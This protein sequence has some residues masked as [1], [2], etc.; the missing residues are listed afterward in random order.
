[1]AQNFLFFIV[2][3]LIYISTLFGC[4]HSKYIWTGL[5]LFWNWQVQVPA[6]KLSIWAIQLIFFM[7]SSSIEAN[8]SFVFSVSIINSSTI[9][10]KS[11]SDLLSFSFSWQY[12]FNNSSKIDWTVQKFLFQIMYISGLWNVIIFSVSFRFSNFSFFSVSFHDLAKKNR[13]VSF[14]FWIFFVP[15]RFVSEKNK[16]PIFRFRKNNVSLFC[17]AWIFLFHRIRFKVRIFHLLQLQ[18]E[19][20]KRNL[21]VLCLVLSNLE[22]LSLIFRLTNQPEKKQICLEIPKGKALT[23][24]GCCASICF[25]SSQ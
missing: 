23:L 19:F 4:L 7:E 10:M 15:F 5:R 2:Y 8:S 13:S 16:V 20:L 6:Q 17:F 18:S 12:I 25:F 9:L 3:L 1:V 11:S 24:Q 21:K 14:S 22:V